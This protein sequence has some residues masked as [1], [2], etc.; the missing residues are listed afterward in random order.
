MAGLTRLL[1]R[2]LLA[3]VNAQSASGRGV[4]CRRI[5][6]AIRRLLF[7][8]LGLRFAGRRLGPVMRPSS[9]PVIAG[10]IHGLFCFCCHRLGSLFGF[11]TNRLSSLLCFLTCGFQPVFN[12]FPCFLRAVLYVLNYAVLAEGS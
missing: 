11:L 12:R 4:C 7:R 8:A 6:L 9:S 5:G 2:S 1:S 3:T 10:A